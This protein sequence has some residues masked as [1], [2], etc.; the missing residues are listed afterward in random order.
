MMQQQK[1]RTKRTCYQIPQEARTEC[2]GLLLELQT[3]TT[4]QDL[5]TVW[6]YWKFSVDQIYTHTL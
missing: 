5:F 6:L 3:N 4:L 2:Y 1:S